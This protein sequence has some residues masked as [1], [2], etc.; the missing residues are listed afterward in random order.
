MHTV[1]NFFGVIFCLESFATQELPTR[2]KRFIM[3]LPVGTVR[4]SRN[5]RRL[6]GLGRSDQKYRFLAAAA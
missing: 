5:S 6:D 1:S 3:E 4:R 2:G